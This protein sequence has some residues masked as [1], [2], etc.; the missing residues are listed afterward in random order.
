MIMN[1]RLLHFIWQMQYYNPN[2]LATVTGEPVKV[3]KAG[4]YNLDQGPDFQQARVM[5]RQ[6]TWAG[7]VELHLRTS[8]WFRHRHQQDKN[9]DN[10]ILH[11]VWQHDAEHN[12]VPV[13]ELE[14]RVP[15]H[16]LQRFE[17]LMA[18]KA[19]IP[20]A[21][22]IG[23][24]DPLHWRNWSERLGVER[25]IRKGELVNQ[26]L[27]MNKCNWDE[28]CWWMLARNFGYRVNMLAFEELARSLPLNLLAKH[29][30]Q[31]IQ[32]EALLMGQAGLLKE[33]LPQDDYY[34]LLQREY[35]FLKEKYGLKPIGQS[36]YFLR[37]RPGNFPTLR[38]AQLAA[39]VHQSSHLFSRIRENHSLQDLRDCF[40]VLANDY[41]HYHYRFGEKTVYREKRLGAAMTDSI[42]INTIAPLLFAYGT[43]HGETSYKE[44]AIQWL[45]KTTAENH[46][47][48][49]GFKKLGVPF[50]NAFDTQ[51]LTELK[52]EYCNHKRCLECGVGSRL[53][54]GN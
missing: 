19:F 15:T 9:Y 53:L 11:V 21:G 5:I 37:M 10:V 6:T 41:W 23:K 49:Q 39:L 1:E 54:K 24:V 38:L 47:I 30:F 18:G 7:N 26:F 14:H 36:V 20:C 48:T 17:D 2:E 4:T 12:G 40:D 3:L 33:P 44:K 28:T 50:R 22:M 46:S 27:A 52:N 45:E 29:R 8:D 13:L 25:L 34:C 43:Y 42:I 32:L 31:L 16:L 35:G 51:A